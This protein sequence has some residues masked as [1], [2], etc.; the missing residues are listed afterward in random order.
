MIRQKPSSRLWAVFLPLCYLA[1]VLTIDRILL[2]R[3]V[4]PPLLTIGLLCMAV[5]MRPVWVGFWS[6]VYSVAVI[7]ILNFRLIYEFFSNASPDPFSHL[8]RSLGFL[9]VAAFSVL[10]S[11]LLTKLR[12]K[13]AFLDQL[14]FRIPSPV[15]VSDFRGNILMGNQRARELLGLPDESQLFAKDYFELLSPPEK[16]QQLISE[17]I[18]AFQRSEIKADQIDLEI[19]GKPIKGIIELTQSK[20]YRLITMIDTGCF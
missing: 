5:L 20:P 8:V 19:N 13:K 9:S 16:R 12:G 4:A 14:M 18:K 3:T 17:Y 10:F 2:S 6:C 7:L 1:F 11:A 15:I